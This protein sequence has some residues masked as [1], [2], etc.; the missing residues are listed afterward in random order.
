M[1]VKKTVTGFGLFLSAILITAYWIRVFGL[2]AEIFY[3]SCLIAAFIIAKKFTLLENKT[4]K[5][6]FI[7]A[8]I[9]TLVLSSQMLYFGYT[10]SNDGLHSILV[11]LIRENE[12]IPLSYAPFAD[13]SFS[14]TAA[15]HSLVS[16]IPFGEA[17]V[18]N[19]VA[20]LISVFLAVLLFTFIIEK[21]TNAFI[22][23][24]SVLL[25][26]GTKMIFLDL[27]HMRST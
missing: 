2:P 21:K 9:I 10:G 19:W 26:L 22:A 20:G 8:I 5:M 6:L 25:L 13:L 15:F 14:Y 27:I 17:F 23:S 7:P 1:N 4:S 16:F 3:I 18:L 12:K 11:D 24:C